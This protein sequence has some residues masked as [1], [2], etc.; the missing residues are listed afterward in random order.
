MCQAASDAY[1]AAGIDPSRIVQ[2]LGHA[3]ASGDTHNMD[4]TENGQAFSAAIDLSVHHPTQLTVEQIKTVLGTM[5][6]HG[7][8]GWYRNPGV[9]YWPAQDEEHMHFAFAGIGMKL[10]LRNQIHDWCHSPMRNGLVRHQ[11]YA[12]WQPNQEMVDVIRAL[13][14]AHNP[15]T[16]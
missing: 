2:T 12:F 4:G 11:A 14:L 6:L 10:S 9:D 16:G 7:F 5:A 3:R 15:T 1:R 8:A 13:F